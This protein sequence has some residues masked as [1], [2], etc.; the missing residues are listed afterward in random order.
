MAR[1]GASFRLSIWDQRTGES[2]KLELL[3]A[4][5]PVETALRFLANLASNG[6]TKPSLVLD[7]P[8]VSAQLAVLSPFHGFR[9]NIFASAAKISGTGSSP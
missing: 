8:H 7:A 5:G 1:A 9:R 3:D 4:P 2:L 6:V